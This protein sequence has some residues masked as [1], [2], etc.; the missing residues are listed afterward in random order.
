MIKYCDFCYILGNRRLNNIAAQ[1]LDQFASKDKYLTSFLIISIYLLKFVYQVRVGLDVAHFNFKQRFGQCHYN[2]KMC[3]K[4]CY[5][6]GHLR[7]IVAYYFLE[8][9]CPPPLASLLTLYI[10]IVSQQIINF[11]YSNLM[12]SNYEPYVFKL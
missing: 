5:K 2:L 7:E 10:Q 1:L 11:I 12:L 6:K 9:H 4:M 3:G 8:Q